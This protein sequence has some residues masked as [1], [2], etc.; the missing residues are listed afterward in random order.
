MS[1]GPA[2]PKICPDKQRLSDELLEAVNAVAEL[3]ARQT[4]NV[5]ES[6]EGLPRFNLALEAARAKWETAR[7]AYLAHVLEHGC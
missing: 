7:E 1:P 6:G 3:Q 2:R 5:I 4:R